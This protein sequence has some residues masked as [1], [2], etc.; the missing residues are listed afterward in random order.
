MQISHSG[1]PRFLPLP[2]ASASGVPTLPHS[3]SSVTYLVPLGP[4]LIHGHSAVGIAG[5]DSDAVALD[6]LLHL[7]LDGHD[8]LPLTI[9]LGQRGLELLMGSDQTLTRRHKWGKRYYS[10]N[11]TGCDVPFCTRANA[12]FN[13]RNLCGETNSG[14]FKDATL[15]TVVPQKWKK[16][17]RMMK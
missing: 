15:C 17:T 9:R 13:C 16:D 1:S 14:C 11:V 8:G 3:R 10:V 6:H 7:V 2:S 12:F 5:T 4:E